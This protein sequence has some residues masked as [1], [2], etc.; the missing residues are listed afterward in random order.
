MMRYF[1]TG[2]SIEG[3][4]GINND[5]DPLVLKLKPDQVNSI[6]AP[7]GVGKSSIFEAIYFAI[8][9]IVPRLE[10]MQDGEDAGSYVVNKFHPRQ[11]ATIILTFGND[12]G[13][14]DVV[15]TVTRDAAGSRSVTSPT[16]ADPEEFLRNLREDF[17]LVDYGRFSNF[18]DTSA[19]ERGRSFANLV[20]LSRYSQ[21]RQSLAG[22]SRTQNLNSDLDISSLEAK[23]KGDQRALNGIAQRLL[24]S[25]NEILGKTLTEVGDPAT[26]EDEV[27][28][29]LAG[30]PLLAAHFAKPG[31]KNADFDAAEKAIEK[32]EGGADRKRLQTL[33]ESCEAL[34][35]TK[36]EQSDLDEVA[37]LIDRAKARD[38][39]IRKVGLPI[40]QDVLRGAL[41]VLSDADWS[42]PSKCPVCDETATTPLTDRLTQKISLYEDATQQ[43]QALCNTII[44]SAFETKL[45]ELE[46]TKP[47]AVAPKEK[48]HPVLTA[49]CEKGSVSTELLSKIAARLAEIETQRVMK[50]GVNTKEL[51]EL[52]AKLPPSMVQVSR[53]I[54]HAKQAR[55][56]FADY[57][58]AKAALAAEEQRLAKLVRWKTF[59]TAAAREFANA[60]TALTTERVAEIQAGAQTLLGSLVRGAP[61]MKPTLERAK[62]KENIDLQLANFF[63]LSGLSAR[64][65]LSESYR[66]AVAASIFLSAALKHK[67]APRFMVL[68]DITSSFDSGHQFSLMDSIRTLLRYGAVPEGLQFIILSHDTSLEKYFDRLNGTADWHHQKLQGMPPKGRVMVAAQQ[69][70]RL[71]AQAEKHLNAGDVELGAP[72][73]RQYMEYKL[74]QV[75][76]RLE[77]PVPPDYATRGD[78][79]TLSTYADAITDAVKLHQKAGVCVLDAGQVTDLLT[80]HTPSI[81]A[82]YVSHYETGAGTPFNAYALLGVL[83]AVDSLAECFMH[84]PSGATQ[85]VYYKRLDRK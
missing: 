14:A 55:D 85:K 52:Q 49:A 30:K 58:K 39:A 10:E 47:L 34:E 61:D 5:G 53:N 15:V 46:E 18:I 40:L 62:D 7:N 75:I 13:A 48:L 70:D 2:L 45:S 36:V 25:T 6:H 56:L 50:L 66:N 1:L 26:L 8:H 29:S 83:Q 41:T 17:T 23:V 60:E 79:R 71:K 63:G 67:G 27:V 68:D 22:A 59:I 31:L 44:A 64:A 73:V 65:L 78:K 21:L 16:H 76:T 12:A 4:R 33:T 24:T 77:I 51:G 80:V 35:A 69:A 54:T 57:S 20:G 11:L 32:E 19:L 42:D 72:F 43:D 3:F 28:K 82:N 37:T 81:M 84:M 38:E 9:G 74:G